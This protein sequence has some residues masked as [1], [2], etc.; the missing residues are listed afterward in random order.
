MKLFVPDDVEQYAHD[1][2]KPLAPL[3]DELRTYTYS[4]VAS[5][6]MQVGRVEGSLLQMLVALCSARRV[7]EIGTFT[8]YSA[9]CM[10]EALPD[11][12][13]LLTCD[14]DEEVTAIA[15]QFFERHPA[16]RKI[17]VKLGDALDTVQA[18]PNEPFFD[19]VFVDADK[20]RYPDYYEAIVPRLRHGGLLVFDNVLW[21]GE[22]LA[23][24]TEDA[25]GI[26]ALN[27]RIT[28]DEQ[29][30]NVMLTVRDGVMLTR[31]R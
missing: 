14:N 21:S 17:T 29:V 2:T 3:F 8:G 19:L 30:D 22:V 4:N 5:P 28:A 25:K 24:E 20:S 11:D 27:D 6:Q 13:E 26:A 18:L 1:H 7:L 9:L 15:A 12:G 10:A 23:P 16:G 31:K